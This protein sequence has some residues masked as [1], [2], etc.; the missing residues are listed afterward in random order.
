MVWD[1]VKFLLFIIFVVFPLGRTLVLLVSDSRDLEV[2]KSCVLGLLTISIVPYLLGV[3]GLYGFSLYILTTLAVLSWVVIKKIKLLKPVRLGLVATI[4]TI[5]VIG[6]NFQMLYPFG[7][8]TSQG[9]SL[10]GAHFIDSTWHLA[11]VNS[12]LR[13]IPPENPDYAGVILKNYHYFSDLQ[14]AIIHNFTSIPIERI[15]FILMGPL[16]LSLTAFSLYSFVCKAFG[17]KLSATLSILLILCASN[18]YYISNLIYPLA[19]VSPSVAWMDFYSSKVVNFPLLYSLSLLFVLLE[20][21]ISKPTKLKS[22]ITLGIISGFMFMV[23]SHTALVLLLSLFLLGSFQSFRKQWATLIIAVIGIAVC[24]TLAY[25]TLSSGSSSLLF[26][27]MWFIKVMYESKYHLN[28][29]D[30]E[31]RRQFLLSVESY[32]GVIKLYIQGLSFFLLVNFALGLVGVVYYILRFFSSRDWEKLMVIIFLVSLTLTLSF[33]YSHSATVTIQFIY[34]A[35][36][37]SQILFLGMLN[38]LFGKRRFV[39]ILIAVIY[40]V[41]LLPGVRFINDQY[42]GFVGQKSISPA[43]TRSLIFA[44][45]LPSGTILTTSEFWSGSFVSAYSGHPVYLGDL[46]TVG[47]SGIDS[48]LR[49]QNTERFFKCQQRLPDE[50]KYIL[51]GVN[52]C[53]DNYAG[54][55]KIF[56]DSNVLIYK[57]QL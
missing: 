7:Q 31:L 18:W 27:P 12:L 48:T 4:L 17:S 49:R 41:T 57:T 35:F 56:S 38:Q 37:S 52:S 5:F 24:V 55:T 29:P 34:T 46:D 20:T 53:V 42:A 15:F 1:I 28:T 25:S 50:I 47:G 21:I 2:I 23:K 40:W 8:T 13:S 54:L 33:I 16:Y 3:L 22:I 9:I 11:L 45:T 51:T 36:I 19:V 43:I 32:L 26:S 10:Y 30:W 39:I 14:I 44:S 6:L